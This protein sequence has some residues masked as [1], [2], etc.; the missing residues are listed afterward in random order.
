[1]TIIFTKDNITIDGENIMYEDFKKS[2]DP[3]KLEYDKLCEELVKKLREV[4][5]QEGYMND[6]T[7]AAL[8]ALTP[9]LTHN[10]NKDLDTKRKEISEYLGAEIASRYYF[11]KGKLIQDLKSDP[12]L[13][14]AEEILSDKATLSKIL[15]PQNQTE[16]KK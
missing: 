10:L 6:E 3:T 12:A 9:L 11:D 15:T 16:T 13:K 4:A 1:M 14:K 5:E 8:D 7:K 2:I